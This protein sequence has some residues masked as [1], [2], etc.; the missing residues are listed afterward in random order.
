MLLY[1]IKLR[2][3][4]SQDVILPATKV[5]YHPGFPLL[6]CREVSSSL[7]ALSVVPQG[8]ILEPVLLKIFIKDK[9]A[10]IMFC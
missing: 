3:L 2:V 5:I 7:P 9:C 8:T 4:N 10:K 1:R 6:A